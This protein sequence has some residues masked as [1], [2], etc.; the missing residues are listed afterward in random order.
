MTHTH[1]PLLYLWICFCRKNAY[2]FVC[3]RFDR[4]TQKTTALQFLPLRELCV[5]FLCV[6]ATRLLRKYCKQHIYQIDYQLANIISCCA[7]EIIFCVTQL[8]RICTTI[9]CV[10]TT[11]VVDKFITFYFFFCIVFASPIYFSSLCM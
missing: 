2:L 7:F 3:L 8:I 5:C 9:L 1:S 4:Q 10:Y 6:F 11:A